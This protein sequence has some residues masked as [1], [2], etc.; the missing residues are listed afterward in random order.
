MMAEIKPIRTAAEIGLAEAFAALRPRQRG[1]ACNKKND[2]VL[3]LRLVLQADPLLIDRDVERDRDPRLAVGGRD[4]DHRQPPDLLDE[5][6]RR[7]RRAIL[8]LPSLRALGNH[9]QQ[10]HRDRGTRGA[11]EALRVDLRERLR[12][13]EPMLVHHLRRKRRRMHVG[14][15]LLVVVL[16]VDRHDEMKS[17][18][19]LHGS[20]SLLLTKLRSRP[21]GRC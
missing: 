8:P 1:T 4:D 10:P 12:K 17:L 18:V 21:R 5:I 9:P 11:A 7:P 13:Q 3:D 14:D 20:V 2:G 15:D 16:V 6:L 19:D